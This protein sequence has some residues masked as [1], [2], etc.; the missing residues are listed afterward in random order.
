[1]VVVALFSLVACI[2]G[3]NNHYEW[4][5]EHAEAFTWDVA[6]KFLKRQCLCAWRNW[7]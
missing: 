6:D 5:T 7:S 1:M 2:F 4:N 3:M